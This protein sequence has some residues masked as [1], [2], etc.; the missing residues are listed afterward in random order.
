MTRLTIFALRL[1]A[2]PFTTAQE[3]L[4]NQSEHRDKSELRKTVLALHGAAVREVTKGS[5]LDSDVPPETLK[6]F[7]ASVALMDKWDHRPGSN[8]GQ[9]EATYRQLIKWSEDG[10]AELGN[11][12]TVTIVAAPTGCS[13]RYQPVIGGP[14]LDAGATKIIKSLEPRWYSFSC[15]C[16][17]PALTQRVDCTEDTT[18]SFTCPAPSGTAK[19]TEKR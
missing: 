18:V 19:P 15:D 11:H 1:L 9:G 14:E 3:T 8:G 7:S 2:V 16:Q 6:R 17:T 12:V 5:S 10:M 4:S 13:V